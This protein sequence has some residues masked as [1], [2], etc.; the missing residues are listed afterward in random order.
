MSERDR[1]IIE[2]ELGRGDI[3]A[4]REVLSIC[5]DAELTKNAYGR[6]AIRIIHYSLG[7]KLEEVKQIAKRL[8]RN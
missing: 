2:Y 3:D 8:E 7:K 6:E 5:V 1:L 4:L